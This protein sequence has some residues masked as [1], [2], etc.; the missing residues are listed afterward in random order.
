MLSILPETRKK[1]IIIYK[2]ATEYNDI[3]TLYIGKVP[4]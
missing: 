4:I 3:G 2:L 1:Y